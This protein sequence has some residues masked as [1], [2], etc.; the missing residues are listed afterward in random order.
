VVDKVLTGERIDYRILRSWNDMK[1]CQLSWVYDVN[2]TATLKR[3][4]ERKFLERV[5][6][7]LPETKDIEKVKKKIFDYVDLRIEKNQ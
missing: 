5:F 2:Y 3:I 4:K 7:F 1:L 6:G